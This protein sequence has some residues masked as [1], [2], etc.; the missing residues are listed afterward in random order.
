MQVFQGLWYVLAGALAEVL[1]PAAVI[2]L[3]MLTV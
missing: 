2:A 1:S 3:M